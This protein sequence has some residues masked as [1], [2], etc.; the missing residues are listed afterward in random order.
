MNKFTFFKVFLK[1]WGFKGKYALILPFIMNIDE[2]EFKNNIEKT[3]EL[4]KIYEDEK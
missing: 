1:I 4:I 2:Q 3:K